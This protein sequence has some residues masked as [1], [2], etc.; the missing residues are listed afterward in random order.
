MV[1]SQQLVSM[2]VQPVTSRIPDHLQTSSS[3]S[4]AISP[5]Y[6]V[7]KLVLELVLELQKPSLRKL[8]GKVEL[9]GQ[10]EGKLRAGSA[11]LPSALQRG[12][13]R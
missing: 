4:Y 1:R 5:A 11:E 3:L 8:P 7:L 6:L 10:L 13:Q 9:M 2:N 12:L